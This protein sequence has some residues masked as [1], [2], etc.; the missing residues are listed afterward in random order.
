M[1]FFKKLFPPKQTPEDLFKLGNE[2]HNYGYLPAAIESY[3]AAIKLKPDYALAYHSRGVVYSQLG[4]PSYA[5]RDFDQAIRLDPNWY[6][7]YM[8]RAGILASQGNFASAIN[9]YS[10]AIS[11]KSQDANLFF[12]R[13]FAYFKSGDAE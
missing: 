12:S 2:E 8:S 11:L 9:N 10:T 13:G 1:E 4:V 3:S 7:P 5:L 6:Y